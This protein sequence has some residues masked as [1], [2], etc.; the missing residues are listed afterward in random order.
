[1]PQLEYTRYLV[2]GSPISMR[3]DN[4]DLPWHDKRVR[5]A[6]TLA[7][8]NQALVDELYGGHG[9]LL[10]H[11]ILPY[12]EFKD[13]YTPLEEQSE[14]VQELFSYNPDKAKQLM[15]DAGYPNGFTCQALCTATGVDNLAVVK[16]YWAKI[17]VDLQIDVRDATVFTGIY[18][19]GK[20]EE[21]IYGTPGS[22]ANQPSKF[23][24]YY[25]VGTL[26]YTR[27]DDARCNEVM[28]T[29]DKLG[30]EFY[31]D[32]AQFC[33]IMKDIYPYILEQCWQIP[34]PGYYTYT[35]WWPWIKDYNGTGG[36]G[37]LN[38]YNYLKYIW[39]DQ[40][41]KKEMGY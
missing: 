2:S 31:T 24:N 7:I 18:S 26:N 21:M 40:D 11:P 12:P 23:S 17:G 15:T 4:P 36:L 27:I 38:T 5:H 6:L 1:M 8:D 28:E 34:M 35:V 41:L 16:D 39:I 33:S 20:Q 30:W 13:M 19:R 29:V 37:Y 9:E 10:A 32:R 3:M 14:T 25:G 22:G